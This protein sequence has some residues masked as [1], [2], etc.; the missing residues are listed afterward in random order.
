VTERAITMGP[1]EVR[2]ILEGA[3]S[4]L[5]CITAGGEEREVGSD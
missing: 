4:Q 3:K 1:V 5:T 2:A